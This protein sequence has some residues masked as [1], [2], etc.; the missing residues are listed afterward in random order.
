MV[1]DALVHVV[2]DALVHM[3]KIASGDALNRCWHL[4]LSC[5]DPFDI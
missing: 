4:E 2:I 1:I 5:R 3:A